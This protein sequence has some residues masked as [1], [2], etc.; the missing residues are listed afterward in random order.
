MCEIPASIPSVVGLRS[1]KSGRWAARRHRLEAAIRDVR[2]YLTGLCVDPC[3]ID[4]EE[5]HHNDFD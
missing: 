2:Q 5:T 3:G 1:G 4:P